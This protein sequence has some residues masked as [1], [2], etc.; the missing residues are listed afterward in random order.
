MSPDLDDLAAKI[1]AGKRGYADNGG[2]VGAKPPDVALVDVDARAELPRVT[3]DD[4]WFGAAGLVELAG[5]KLRL[6]DFPRDGRVHRTLIE[7]GT[8]LIATGF[9]RREARAGGEDVFETRAGDRRAA[10]RVGER[11]VRAIDV[12]L[13]CGTIHFV[14]RRPSAFRGSFE[15]LGDA[16]GLI[17][18]RRRAVGVGECGLHVFLAISVQRTQ[19]IRV[20]R[21]DVGFGRGEPRRF[22]AAFERDE[23]GAL[24]DAVAFL[25]AHFGD[26][27]AHVGSNLGLAIRRLDDSVS[28]DVVAV[29]DGQPL[30]K[31]AARWREHARGAFLVGV[32]NGRRGLGEDR[33]SDIEAQE[34]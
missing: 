8:R 27:S 34:N 3:H 16:R 10:F 11:R 5:A 6:Q 21:L 32:A 20:G 30:I 1:F 33:A 24:L 13:F 22:G 28:A 14:W 15:P 23:D 4:E 31:G 17:R 9:G 29:R 12:R 7:R 18:T 25:D 26:A 2:R 19:E